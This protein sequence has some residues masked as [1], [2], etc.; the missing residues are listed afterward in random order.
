MKKSSLLFERLPFSKRGFLPFLLTFLFFAA[1]Q[2][3]MNGQSHPF[4]GPPGSEPVQGK[5]L[6]NIPTGQFVSTAIAIERLQAE[7]N[8]LKSQLEQLTEGTLQYR[9][10]IRRYYYYT[11]IITELD[12][13]SV[14]EAITTGL[15]VI[16]STASDYVAS[17][18]EAAAEKTRAINLLRL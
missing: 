4:V 8:L 5:T 15:V 11:Q 12:Y 9:Q 3:D 6:G 13:K 7:L 10:T 18:E 14:A 16:R 17:P 2:L 1:L